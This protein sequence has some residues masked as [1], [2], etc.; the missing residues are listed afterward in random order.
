MNKVKTLCSKFN[1][2][3]EMDQF[4]ERYSLRKVTSHQSEWPSLHSLQTVNFG[5]GVKKRKHSCIVSGNEIVA[6][7]V[8][9]CMEVP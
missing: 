3:G 6:T 5:K 9:N 1:N 2:I 8:E 7:N 4:L